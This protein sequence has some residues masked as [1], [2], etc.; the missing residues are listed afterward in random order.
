MIHQTYARNLAQT[1]QWAF[2]PGVPSAASTSPLYT[3]VL[4]IGY[5]LNLPFRLWTHGLGAVMLGLTGMLGLRLAE[6]SRRTSSG[7]A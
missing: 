5:W 2:V 1:G 7:S 3:V 4:T 6:G